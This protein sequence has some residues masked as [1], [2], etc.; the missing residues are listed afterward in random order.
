MKI[1]KLRNRLLGRAVGVFLGVVAVSSL[2]FA[3]SLVFKRGLDQVHVQMLALNGDESDLQRTFLMADQLI[4]DLAMPRRDGGLQDSEIVDWRSRLERLAEGEESSFDT[5]TSVNYAPIRQAAIDVEEILAGRLPAEHADEFVARVIPKLR[6]FSAEVRGALSQVQEARLQL[7]HEE[8]HRADFGALAMLCV[9]FIGFTVVCL[10]TG[11]F[12]LQLSRDVGRLKDRANRIANRDYGQP[13]NSGRKDEVGDLDEALNVMAQA[14]AETERETESARR[15][16]CQA[17]KMSALGTFAMGIAHEIGNPIQSVIVLCEM[18]GDSLAEDSGRRNA[19]EDRKHLQMIV[20]Q[21]DRMSS[22]LQVFSDFSSPAPVKMEPISVN[23]ALESA[24]QLLHFDPRF[25]GVRLA[26]NLSRDVP[27]VCGAASQLS[28]VAV[29][30]L[31]N[32]ADAIDGEEGTIVVTSGPDR[33]DALIRIED[34]GR[35]M[36]KEICGE[37]LNPFFTTKPKGEGT[38]LG[39]A[40]CKAIIDE[41]RGTLAIDSEPGR[42]TRVQ[43]R[44]PSMPREGAP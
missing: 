34:N 1:A 35:G 40:I 22:A 33:D 28:Q 20:E 42:G 26:A 38:G 5:R 10:L 8:E 14:L 37:A 39:L 18:L 9:G 44:I 27:V 7:I 15:R 16:L 6:G 30:I 43:I 3:L 17:E 4:H 24:I 41:H 31:I 2:V 19:A 21:V 36:S 32:A 12:F 11:R 25:R 29:N 23:S 13:F